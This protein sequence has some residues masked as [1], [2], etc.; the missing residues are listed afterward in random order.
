MSEYGQ[1]YDIYDFSEDKHQKTYWDLGS[2]TYPVLV[3]WA[4]Q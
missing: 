2:A 4:A 1:A 3:G